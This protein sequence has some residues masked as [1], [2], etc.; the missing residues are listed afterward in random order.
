MLTY[1]DRK[2]SIV[3]RAPPFA[4]G[5]LLAAL[6]LVACAPE[7]GAEPEDSASPLRVRLMTGEQ[8]SNT[9]A[10]IFGR[11]ISDSVLPPLPPLARTDGLLSSGAAY[12]GVTSDQL[13]QIQQAA[14]SIAAKVVDEQGRVVFDGP[15]I[16]GA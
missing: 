4:A 12:V 16:V 6:L 13:Q 11:D 15:I 7:R 10:Q 1:S 9:I 2:P 5:G 3:R 14:A 8:Y